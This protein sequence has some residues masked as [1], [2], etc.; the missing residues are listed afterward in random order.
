VSTGE[1]LGTKGDVVWDV[2]EMK[3][4]LQNVRSYTRRAIQRAEGESITGCRKLANTP[5]RAIHKEKQQDDRGLKRE[6]AESGKNK[7]KT[8]SGVKKVGDCKPLCL[9]DET[10]YGLEEGARF[11]GKLRGLNVF[12]G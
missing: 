8:I 9:S 12:W 5:A 7:S 1:L 10:V 4:Q 6:G 11:Q 3:Y 2:W